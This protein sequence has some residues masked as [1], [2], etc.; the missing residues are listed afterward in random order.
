MEYDTNQTQLELEERGEYVRWA[1]RY[2]IFQHPSGWFLAHNGRVR[3]PGSPH[4]IDPDSSS[5]HVPVAHN[6][7]HR[8]P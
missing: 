6:G 2:A 7:R 3:A 1:G 8:L 4:I 5:R